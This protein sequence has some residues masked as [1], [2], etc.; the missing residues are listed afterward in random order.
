[1]RPDKG[2]TF[3]IL[4][5]VKDMVMKSPFAYSS[6]SIFFI[7]QCDGI[8]YRFLKPNPHISVGSALAKNE[9]TF[10]ITNPATTFEHSFFNNQIMLS[11]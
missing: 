2:K 11:H 3:K 10:K 4:G 1:M 7:N 5:V 8:N 9:T 6:P